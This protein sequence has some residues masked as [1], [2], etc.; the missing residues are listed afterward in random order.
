MTRDVAKF[1]AKMRE[2]AKSIAYKRKHTLLIGAPGSGKVMIARRVIEY[3]KHPNPKDSGAVMKMHQQAGLVPRGPGGTF[4]VPF[5]APH[6]TVSVEGLTGRR[7]DPYTWIPRFG[8]LSL[9]HSGVFFMDEAPEFSRHAIEAVAAA[10]RENT[11]T[12]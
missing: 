2:I 1:E 9:A 10:V 6:H 8:E 12:T 4:A 5:R 3:L 11:R 7:P